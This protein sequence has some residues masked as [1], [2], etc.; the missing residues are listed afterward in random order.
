MQCDRVTDA[1]QLFHG[2]KR[3]SQSMFAV[4]IKGNES[5]LSEISN[6]ALNSGQIGYTK[7]RMAQK[8]L[9]LFKGIANPSEILVLLMLNACA[10]L[11]SRDALEL[12]RRAVDAMPK[13]YEKNAFILNSAFDMFIKCGDVASAESLFQR[14]NRFL[15]GYGRLMKIFNEE[16]QP[17]K[18]LALYEQMKLDRCKPDRV[19]YLLLINACS[20][21]GIASTCQRICGNIPSDLLRDYRIKSALID[22]WVSAII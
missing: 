12:A 3:R 10:Q 6:A 5:G 1:E 19:I 4:M 21:I 20:Q 7:H 18:T 8:G 13:T 22:M 2:A 15:I 14:M 17:E 11:G 16:K 9:D